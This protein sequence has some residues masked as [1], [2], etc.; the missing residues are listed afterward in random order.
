M[1]SGDY[2]PYQ[3]PKVCIW[4]CPTKLGENLKKGSSQTKLARV[5]LKGLVKLKSGCLILFRYPTHDFTSWLGRGVI[6]MMRSQFWIFTQPHVKW[7]NGEP[8][9][10]LGVDENV[11]GG[12]VNA[13]NRLLRLLRWE[14]GIKMSLIV[15]LIKINRNNIVANR[16]LIDYSHWKE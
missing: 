15:T 2:S 12:S 10:E 14:R 9:L 5:K 8:F 13:T 1:G 11:E 16:Q 3:W 6:V 4:K 7:S